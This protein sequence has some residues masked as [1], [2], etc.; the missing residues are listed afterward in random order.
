M[1]RDMQS[2]RYDPSR[3]PPF[4]SRCRSRPRP[5]PRSR[6]PRSRFSDESVYSDGHGVD[7]DY[8]S[9]SPDEHDHD[10]NVE[11][12]DI[13]TDDDIEDDNDNDD[14]SPLDSMPKPRPRAKYATLT[15]P[16]QR[17]QYQTRVLEA[18]SEVTRPLYDDGSCSPRSSSS[19][20]P[21]P[22]PA[23]PLPLPRPRPKTLAD[24]RDTVS[25][26]DM[27]F[28][29]YR[30]DYHI[31]LHERARSN[32]FS[33]CRDIDDVWQLRG[34]QTEVRQLDRE[35]LEMESADDKID[36]GDGDGLLDVHQ[37]AVWRRGWRARENRV[38]EVKKAWAGIVAERKRQRARML[39]DRRE[40]AGKIRF[41]T[42]Q[43]GN[44][45]LLREFS[46]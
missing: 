24:V 12:M 13:D 31:H 5:R 3:D 9:I 38:R 14:V 35:V 27:R 42:R 40:Q 16:S 18:L 37:M 39:Q 28:A 41:Y 8:A 34:W 44:R 1:D 29:C 21:A 6:R 46:L 20:A 43:Q 15:T 33:L 7:S 25:E 26:D 45:V 11:D 30:V 17:Q 36:G 19:P 22:T 4:L 2:G 10:H 32:M 23:L